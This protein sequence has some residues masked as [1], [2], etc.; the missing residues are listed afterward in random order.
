MHRDMGAAPTLGFQ[1]YGEADL[2]RTG[3]AVLLVKSLKKRESVAGKP[4]LV[5]QPLESSQ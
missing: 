4:G 1:P 2:G 3:L 5:T